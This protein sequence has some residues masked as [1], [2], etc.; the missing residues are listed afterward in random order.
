MAGRIISITSAALVTLGTGAVNQALIVAGAN[1]PIKIRRMGISP[2]GTSNA[3]ARIQWSLT[4]GV[5]ATAGGTSMTVGQAGGHSQG[6][7]TLQTT[8]TLAPTGVSGGTVV[9]TGAFL[10]NGPYEIPL[11]IDLNAA[12]KLMLSTNVATSQNAWIWFELEE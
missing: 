7:G 3:D 6:T 11:N 8:A 9:R 4:K 5:T 2:V 10:P 12:E 1:T